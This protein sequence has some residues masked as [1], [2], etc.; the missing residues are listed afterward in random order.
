ML[1]LVWS[2]YLE[3]ITKNLTQSLLRLWHCHNFSFVN[4][5][6]LNTLVAFWGCKLCHEN[7]SLY[8]KCF[9]TSF[10]FYLCEFQL[11]VATFEWVQNVLFIIVFY[12]GCM[13]HGFEVSNKGF[14]GVCHLLIV[15]KCYK[16][17][18]KLFEINF[19]RQDLSLQNVDILELR[20]GF[21]S[22]SCCFFLFW[23]LVCL[24]IMCLCA[25]N[26]TIESTTTTPPFINLSFLFDIKENSEFPFHIKVNNG[27]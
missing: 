27:S 19:T 25:T 26:S 13:P 18:T 3:F 10:Y 6:F 12:F 11:V 17:G 15:F 5:C 1:F 21:K 14:G 20:C 2:C 8:L 22:V 9:E 24:L 7:T 16:F 23:L 4:E